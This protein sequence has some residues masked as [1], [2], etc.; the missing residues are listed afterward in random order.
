MSFFFS[1]FLLTLG[2]F[3]VLSLTYRLFKDYEVSGLLVQYSLWIY[4]FLMLIEGNLQFFTYLVV[5]EFST[6]FC[7]DILD[8]FTYCFLLTLFFGIVWFGIF[9]YFYVKRNCSK[10]LE[11]FFDNV[12]G[13]LV[14]VMY[15]VFNFGIRNVLLGAAHFFFEDDYSQKIGV[16]MFLELSFLALN[17]GLI[18]KDNYNQR[19]DHTKETK[20]ST[21]KTKES[22][23]RHTR[24][25]KVIISKTK[26]LLDGVTSGMLRIVLIATFM[27]S[28]EEMSAEVNELYIKISILL[29][30]SL[31]I[32]YLLAILHSIIEILVD[33]VVFL[34]VWYSKFDDEDTNVVTVRTIKPKK[35]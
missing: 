23:G 25:K 4:L 3:A 2:L 22:S 5:F 21:K 10:H 11:Y 29:T 18:W 27:L 8:K 34:K 9:I 19:Q 33:L 7:R 35:P 14:G 13:S 16:L 30:Y 12:N 17:V 20:E 28:S 32:A 26:I 1:N 15:I 6:L 31:L 24:S